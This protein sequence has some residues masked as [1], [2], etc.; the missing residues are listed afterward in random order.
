MKRFVAI[1]LISILVFSLTACKDKGEMQPQDSSQEASSA[2]ESSAAS[3][4]ETSS[5]KPTTENDTSSTEKPSSVSSKPTQSNTVVEEN[6]DYTPT[7]DYYRLPADA[8]KYLNSAAGGVT[9]N[10]DLYKRMVKAYLNYETKV[11]MKEN[12]SPFSVLN[13]LRFH[14]PVFFADTKIEVDFAADLETVNIKYTTKSKSEHNKIIKKFEDAVKPIISGLSNATDTEKALVSYYRYTKDLYYDERLLDPNLSWTY[15]YYEDNIRYDEGY[16]ALVNK[17]GVCS[18]FTIAYNFILAQLGIDSYGIFAEGKTEG[19][20]WN[21]MK[22]NGK[23]YFADPTFDGDWPDGDNSIT[24]FGV[25]TQQR[26]L[27]GYNPEY[28]RVCNLDG[29]FNGYTVKD[30][31]FAAL[32]Q[33]AFRPEFDLEN[34]TMVYYDK[35]G[36]KQKVFDIS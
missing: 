19:H 27:L 2:L 3:G 5:D 12:E 26:V 16:Q 13:M 17:K 18:S 9:G 14:C 8:D 1:L 32:T 11:K 36:N 23:W 15:L 35:K 22:L 20:A 24:N 29:K 25:T 4:T 28:Y 10:L 6:F 30:L 33:G 34:H 21:M 31:R 7:L